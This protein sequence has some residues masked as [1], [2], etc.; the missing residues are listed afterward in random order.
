LFPNV[1]GIVTSLKAA[2]LRDVLTTLQRRAP[3]IQVI[4]YPTTVQGTQ[5]A[6]EIAAAINCART[7]LSI[8]RIETL[9]ICRGGG[10]IEDLWSFN[11]EIVARAIVRL[12]VEGGVPVVSG[13]GHETDFTICDFV[14]DQRAPTPTAAAELVSPDVADLRAQVAAMHINLARTLRRVLDNAGQRLDRAARN[15]ISPSE[16]LHRERDRLALIAARVR[17]AIVAQ[18]DTCRFQRSMLHQRLVANAIDFRRLRTDL[19]QRQR[20]ISQLTATILVSKRSQFNA[21]SQALMFLDPARVL[22]RGYS[23]VEHRGSVLRDTGRVAVGDFLRVRLAHGTLEASVTSA[24]AIT[25]D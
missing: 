4:V 24:A 5:A 2:A 10:S 6:Q 19:T 20:Q 12:Q 23:I 18:L 17:N 21:A 7:R 1:L 9:I 14:A 25:P 22:E 13:V 11:E 3:M 16:R 8:D 15:L